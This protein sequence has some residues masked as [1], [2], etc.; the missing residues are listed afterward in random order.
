MKERAKTM[1][2]IARLAKVSKPTVSRALS[3]SPLVNE[4]TRQH[5]LAVAAEHGYTVNR[6]AQKLRRCLMCGDEFLSEWSGNRI[7]KRCKSST[8]WRSGL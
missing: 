4:V 2:D 7:C 1:A 6:N 5:V 3:N 8:A